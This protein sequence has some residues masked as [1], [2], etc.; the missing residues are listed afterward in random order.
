MR[1]SAGNVPREV[2]APRNEGADCAWP[3]C[4]DIGR[5]RAPRSRR[6]LDRYLWFC[7]AH[8]RQYNAAWNYYAGMSEREVEDDIRADTVWQRPTWRLGSAPRPLG[9]AAGAIHDAF[10]LFGSGQ[11]E[12][13]CPPPPAD[14]KALAVLELSP[15]VTVA[16]VKARYKELVKRFHPDLNGGDKAAEERFKE[17]SEAYRMMMHVLVT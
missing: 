2:A 1:H 10:G 5:Y 6:E 4:V 15:P 12:L 8:V 9:A 17:I 11:G 14:Q 7:L 16:I 13:R 3:G